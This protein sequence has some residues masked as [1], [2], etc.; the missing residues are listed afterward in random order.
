MMTPVYLNQQVQ[1]QPPYVH[2]TV[3]APEMATHGAHSG[4]SVSGQQQESGVEVRETGL[5]PAY[6]QG[7]WNPMAMTPE[8]EK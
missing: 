2:V 5:P 7:S 6:A 4:A 3:E 1:Q 8:K